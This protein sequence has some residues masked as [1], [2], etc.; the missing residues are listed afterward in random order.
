MNISKIKDF[1]HDNKMVFIYTFIIVF[2]LFV[3]S[4]LIINGSFGK[5][6]NAME[7][8]TFDIR[9][10]LIADKKIVSDE[11]RI[12]TVDDES[13]EYVINKYG[14]WP[15]PRYVYAEILDY[16]ESQSPAVVGFDLLFVHSMRNNKNSDDRLAAAFAKYDNAFTAIN[17]DDTDFNVRKPVN[18]PNNLASKIKI[19][20]SKF[21]PDLYKNCR[22]IL[23]QIIEKTPNIGHINTAKDDD[24]ITRSIPLYIAY[25]DYHKD[26][27]DNF[28]FDKS[29]I[30]YYPYMTYKLALKYISRQKGIPYEKLLSNSISVQN[31]NLKIMGEY[32]PM[33]YDGRVILNWYGETGLED[34]KNFKY[35]PMWKVIE[36][37][38]NKYSKNKLADDTFTDKV[39]FVGTSVFSLSDIKSVPTS[40]YM[41]GVEVHATLFNNLLNNSFIKP[42]S[43]VQNIIFAVIL[44]GIIAFVTLYFS[45]VLVSS[46][47]SIVLIT[48]Y[49]IMSTVVMLNCNI[50]MWVV[51]PVVLSLISIICVYIIKYLLKSRDFELTYKLATTDGLTDLYNHRFFQ[52]QMSMCIADCERYNRKFSLIMI[53]IDFFKK[54]NDT[55]GHQAGD[56]VLRGVA[57]T[58]KKNVRSSDVVCRYGGEEMTI[59]LKDT[60]FEQAF[61]AAQKICKTIAE[62][63]YKI[64]PNTEKQVTIS[65]GVATYPECG[66]TTQEMIEYA[67]KGLYAAKENG[68][69]QVGRQ[70]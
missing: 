64:A 55:Y 58:L 21:S 49:L 8:K 44:A 68:R 24:G 63:P 39:V 20:S 7:L 70:K 27:N 18:L 57:H 10:S 40:K 51:L 37:M 45:S 29:D 50:W 3:F 47:I 22:S 12:I 9:Q 62:K 6:L 25:P 66:K 1:F 31:N 32:I 53:D 2:V 42:L 46:L 13:Y 41:P 65:L 54:F 56:A 17:F 48:G 4:L 43:N 60:D 23:P 35:I 52:E 30:N 69:N 5:F 16:I 26:E 61:I 28:V 14:E 11:I 36:S 59:I 15:I 34:S 38:E 67:D 33:S 19:N